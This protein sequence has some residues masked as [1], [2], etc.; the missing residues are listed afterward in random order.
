MKNIFLT[1]LAMVSISQTAF[2]ADLT[3]ATEATYPPF[4]AMTSNHEMIG[5]GPEVV[6]AV[7]KQMHKTCKLV[8]A[9]W[10]SLIPSLKMGKYD[11]LFGGMAITQARLA[12]VD[13]STAYY[14]N[15][16]TFVVNKNAKFGLTQQDLKGKVIGVQGGTTFPLYL[17]Q[18]YGKNITI[19]TYAS[20]MT[21]LLDLKSGRVNAVFLDKPVGTA[22][23]EKPVN[24]DYTS[25]GS[26]TDKAIF[27]PGNAIAI[28]KNNA[29]LKNSIDKALITLKQNGEL[30]KLQQKWF[31]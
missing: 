17:Q 19:K 9:P 12:V 3:F 5:Y 7:C 14:Q 24:S 28:G 16:I 20:N 10:E 25:V 6:Q 22:W 15:T 27:G 29:A 21:A 8:N 1:L 18:V 31:K 4:V 26:I 11:A 2:A 13:F 30:K 23:L